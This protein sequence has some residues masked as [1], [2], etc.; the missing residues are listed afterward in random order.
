ML[1][2]KKY[3]IVGISWLILTI[4]WWFF[5]LKKNDI[6]WT[7]NSIFEYVPKNFD[8]IFYFSMQDDNVK[9]FFNSTTTWNITTE[10]KQYLFQTKEVLVFQ[11]NNEE[12]PFSFALLRLK[13][14]FDYE[15]F[16]NSSFFGSWLDYD[17]L[18]LW[19]DLYLYSEKQT[20]DIYKNLNFEPITSI[21]LLNPY[22]D[23]LINKKS[24][25]WFVADI[26]WIDSTLNNVSWISQY[27]KFLKYNVVL[28][29]ISKD[30][31]DGSINILFDKNLDNFINYNYAS[32][33]SQYAVKDNFVYF[34]IGSIFNMLWINESV[35]LNQLKIAT[36]N[37]FFTNDD[38]VK[39]V[40]LFKWNIAFIIGQWDNPYW[41]WWELI[42]ESKDLY[43]LWSKYLPYLKEMIWLHSEIGSIQLLEEENSISVIVP[44][45]LSWAI[46]NWKIQL[47]L[48]WDNS[49]LSL[50]SPT[51][52]AKDSNF[53][54]IY[55]EKS[56]FHFYLNIWLLIEKLKTYSL[57]LW[58]EFSNSLEQF[59]YFEWKSIYWD[60]K[61][62]PNSVIF[63][64]QTK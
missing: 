59:E 32:K 21:S 10:M 47:S 9:D 45:M 48:Q 53:D 38:L 15:S 56:L 13:D 61:V 58:P 36:Q 14:S 25:I 26:S 52:S 24:N 30:N 51:Y 46:I 29:K 2:T 63:T 6:F 27:T 54:L 3:L 62:E 40:N 60:L 5:L 57:F 28:S 35:I 23:K 18:S 39:I 55:N 1:N 8:Q 64:F 22:L 16:K 44:Q 20:I 42:V 37:S 17:V 34:E 33:F 43:S 50:L 7:K 4:L 49:H 11:W 19:N 41:V 12:K 31:L